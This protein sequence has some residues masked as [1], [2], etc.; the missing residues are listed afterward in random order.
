MTNASQLT[1]TQL[2]ATI[3]AHGGKAAKYLDKAEEH[4]KAQGIHLMEAKARIAA[5][6]YAG[7]FV[8]YLKDECKGLSSSRAYELIAIANGTKTIASIREA[9]AE[10]VQRSRK[11]VRYVAEN[12]APTAE[13]RSCVEPQSESENIIDN[14]DLDSDNSQEH[15][16]NIGEMLL[17]LAAKYPKPKDFHKWLDQNGYSTMSDEQRVGALFVAKRRTVLDAL[18]EGLKRG[19]TS[20]PAYMKF[21]EDSWDDPIGPR[22]NTDAVASADYLVAGMARTHGVSPTALRKA[23]EESRG[24]KRTAHQNAVKKLAEKMKADGI[25][26][27]GIREVLH[28][29][30][31]AHKLP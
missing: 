21:L 8:K 26:P 11:A 30:M 22:R 7:G 5:G 18:V 13:A 20:G 1:L 9:T 3:N 27:V 19:E 12:G 24:P 14:G 16:S 2:A 6:E 25:D 10:R 31:L 29:E 4:F 23:A 15:W 28:E 17:D